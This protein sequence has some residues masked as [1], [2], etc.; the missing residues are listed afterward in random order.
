MYISSPD[1]I[2]ATCPCDNILEGHRKSVMMMTTKMKMKTTV[3]MM[4]MKMMTAVMMT[5]Q[6]IAS[7]LY[8][9][10]CMLYVVYMIVRCSCNYCEF[11]NYLEIHNSDRAQLKFVENYVLIAEKIKN[12][13][14]I[15]FSKQNDLLI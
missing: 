10:Y 4:L 15:I 6:F 7:L 12:I 9:V 14:L 5:D 1:G 11:L 3:V 8:V 13:C 2:S